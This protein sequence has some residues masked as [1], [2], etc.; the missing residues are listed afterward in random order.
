MLTI[1]RSI[2][3]VRT[4][5]LEHPVTFSE[6]LDEVVQVVEAVSLVRELGA[7]DQHCKAEYQ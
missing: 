7:T 5:R 1:D 3:K 2:L 6:Q 4:P